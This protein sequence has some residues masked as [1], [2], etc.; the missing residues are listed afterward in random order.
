MIE[1]VRTND[2]VLISVIEGILAQ[3]EERRNKSL[4]ARNAGS[5]EDVDKAEA[6]RKRS[7]AQVES[8][9]ASLQQANSDFDTNILA[10]KAS[11]ESAKASVP[12][13]VSPA[14]VTS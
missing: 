3:V 4:L 12:M 14:P 5:R 7:E 11:V 1:L 9:Q 2:L 13:T 10:A 8:D 6:A